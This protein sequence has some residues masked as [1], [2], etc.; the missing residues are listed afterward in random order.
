MYLKHPGIFLASATA[1]LSHTG[2]ITRIQFFS[3]PGPVFHV[4]SLLSWP[5]LLLADSLLQLQDYVFPGFK[6]LGKKNLLSQ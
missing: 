2:D 3:I 5:L 1:G 4:C 6:P